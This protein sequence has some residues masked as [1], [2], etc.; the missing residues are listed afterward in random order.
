MP[1]GKFKD[2]PEEMENFLEKIVN[3][4]NKKQKTYL[5]C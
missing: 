1:Q 2:A 4:R 3:G 5:L